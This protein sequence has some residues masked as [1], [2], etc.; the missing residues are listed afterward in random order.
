MAEAQPLA[1]RT[2]SAVDEAVER[3]TRVHE[4]FASLLGP[5]GVVDGRKRGWRVGQAVPSAVVAPA[6]EDEVAAC[7]R[8]ASEHGWSVV[9]AGAGSWLHA[10]NPVHRVDVVLSVGRMDRIV[11]YE[12]ADVTLTAGAGLTLGGVNRAVS[13]EGQWLPVDPPG[14]DGGTLGGTLATASAGGLRAA[15]GAPRDLVLGLR[16]VT[17]D[18]RV[19]RLGGRVVKNVAGFDLVKLVVGSWGTL[20][21]ITEATFRLF[22]RPQR[23]LCLVARA[24]RLED[25]MA[26]GGRVARAPIVPAAVELIERPG[27]GEPGAQREAL[28]V[29]RLA[30]L[31]ERVEREAELL[32]SRIAPLEVTRVDGGSPEGTALIEQVRRID[33]ECDV[34]LR[35]VGPL[36]ELPDVLAVARAAGRLRPGRDELANTPHRI[37]VDAQTGSVTVAVPS[38]RVDPPWAEHWVERIRE[39][40]ENMELR[41]GSLTA[42]APEPVVV[43]AGTWGNIGGAERLMRALKAQFDPGWVLSPGRMLQETS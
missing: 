42:Y 26:A 36:A 6:S 20:G 28:L 7:L 27:S 1:V 9:P 19:L 38:V 2:V 23:E 22:P 24:D 33:D 13:S 4:A 21:V 5:E 34:S 40:R 8:L 31:D 43:S 29:V 41:G 15:Y 16:L 12:P 10:G 35:L 30:G 37:R 14:T 32:E 3:Y 25:L 18:G 11:Q 17:G 39:L